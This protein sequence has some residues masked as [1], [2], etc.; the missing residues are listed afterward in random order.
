MSYLNPQE[1]QKSSANSPSGPEVTAEKPTSPEAEALAT[2]EAFESVSADEFKVVFLGAVPI[3]GQAK[4]VGSESVNVEKLK[5][6]AASYIQRSEQ[7]SI[8]VCLRPRDGVLIQIDDCSAEVLARLRSFSFVG[9]ETSVGSFQPWL[10]LP[11]GTSENERLAV[12]ERLLRQLKDTGA[13]GGAFNSVRFPGSL[14]V[15][16]KYKAALGEYPRVR[17]VYT[18]PGRIVTPLELDHAGLLA[19]VQQKPK[20]EPTRYTSPNLPTH[21]PDFNGHLQRKWIDSENRPDRS[22]AEISWCM[23]ALRMGWPRHMVVSEL[24]RLSLK[25][26]GR[27]DNYIEKTVDAA[28]RLLASLPQ[29]SGASAGGRVRITI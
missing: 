2:A 11:K 13:N 17:L 8:S 7:E 18:S 20:I 1:T 29:T 27:R 16:E 25:G 14:N 23:A 4:C 19:P 3:G 9:I 28:I 21:W 10:A 22:S 12:R 6:R 15:K 24:E 26:D 5:L